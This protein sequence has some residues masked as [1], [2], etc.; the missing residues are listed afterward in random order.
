MPS[1]AQ[2]AIATLLALV[3]GVASSN[4]TWS[5]PRTLVYQVEHPTYGN[6]GTYTN[7]IIQNGDSIDIQTDLHVAVRVLG[8][9]LFHQD[10]KRVEHWE[11][12]R[13]ISFHGG[14]DDNGREIDVDGKAQ[15]D[16]FVVQSPFGNFTAP[17][18]VHPSNP[19]GQQCLNTDTMMGTKTGK[20]MKVAVTD[21]G[22]VDLVF[23]GKPTRLHQYFIDS[24]KHQVVWLDDSGVVAGFETEEA[25]TRIRFLLK[26][27]GKA[28]PT[29]PVRDN[30]ALRQIDP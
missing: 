22:I 11:S 6:V 13:L 16:A 12:G 27:D 10:A 1:K 20:V 26:Q 15:G 2:I 23:D 18:R 17:A 3:F 5:E 8:V 21:T 28:T 29:A 24:D 7:V 4:P 14:T 19:W 25:G 9:R 30:V